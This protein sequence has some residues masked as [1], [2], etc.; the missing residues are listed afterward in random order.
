MFN[1]IVRQQRG[2]KSE[3]YVLR[4]MINPG[5][6]AIIEKDLLPDVKRIAQHADKDEQATIEEARRPVIDV[7]D[8]PDR[9]SYA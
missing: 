8:P 7:D 2:R 9:G 4:E 6:R 5:M 1:E 3:Y